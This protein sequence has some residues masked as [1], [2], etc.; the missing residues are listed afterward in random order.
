MIWNSQYG[1][2]KTK[3]YLTNLIN[4]C[5]KIA[6]FVD[7]GR[8]VDVIYLDFINVFS[9]VSHNT[10]VSK[11]ICHS[12]DGW[13]N[14]WVWPGSGCCGQLILLCLGTKQCHCLTWD[15]STARAVIWWRSMGAFIWGVQMTTNWRNQSS[16]SKAGLS[17][18]R[19][20]GRL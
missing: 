4:F 1:F 6:W 12:L 17:L 10:L 7:K 18:K 19:D 3:S 9:T 2:I 14:R 5:G 15:L 16:C 8:V 11:L 13:I 20:L